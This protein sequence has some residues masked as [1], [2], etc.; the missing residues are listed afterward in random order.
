VRSLNG[1]RRKVYAP[2]PLEESDVRRL[3]R[4]KII[5]GI[6]PGEPAAKI[7]TGEGAGRRC[8]ACGEPIK[9]TEIE[10][11]RVAGRPSVYLHPSCFALWREQCAHE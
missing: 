2:G 4:T 8:D 11:E 3:I 6:L 9:E 1:Y 5:A 7:W 10:I